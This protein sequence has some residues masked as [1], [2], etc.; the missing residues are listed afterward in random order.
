MEIQA[1][2]ERE[3]QSTGSGRNAADATA[4][5][6]GHPFGIGEAI[7]PS[8]GHALNIEPGSMPGLWQTQ[9]ILT[10]PEDLKV[11]AIQ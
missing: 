5:T 9:L 7:R 6:T 2:A 11:T 8:K 4:P 1:E 3:D 10:G